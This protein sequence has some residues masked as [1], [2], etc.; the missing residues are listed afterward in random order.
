[1]AN[2]AE[3]SGRFDRAELSKLKWPIAWNG[4]VS[5]EE[6]AEYEAALSSLVAEAQSA[7]DDNPD[8]VAVEIVSGEVVSVEVV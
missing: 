6:R 1:M 7:L 4:T 2:V 5:A 3:I 8:A